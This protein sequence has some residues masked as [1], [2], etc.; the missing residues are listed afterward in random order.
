MPR[1]SWDAYYSSVQ[2][3]FFMRIFVRD[4]YWIGQTTTGKSYVRS[5]VDT[6]VSWVIGLENC[7]TGIKEGKEKE[8]KAQ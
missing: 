7:L 8:E 1:E 3:D 6:L 2:N 5:E 4:E